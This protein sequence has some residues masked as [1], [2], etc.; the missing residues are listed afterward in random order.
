LQ[1]AVEQKAADC[2]LLLRHRSAKNKA[3]WSQQAPGGFAFMMKGKPL[4]VQNDCS[5][6][7]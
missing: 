4:T 2:A 3:P 6:A 5:G 7:F 1:K